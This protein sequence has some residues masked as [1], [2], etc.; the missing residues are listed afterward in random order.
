MQ[1][2]YMSLVLGAAIF[3]VAVGPSLAG[4]SAEQNSMHHQQVTRAKKAL[5]SALVALQ[6]SGDWG[7]GN[8]GGQKEAAIHG[9]ETAITEVNKEIARVYPNKK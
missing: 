8:V 4:Q 9:V 1:K 6:A 7:G 3:G 5:D 2:I